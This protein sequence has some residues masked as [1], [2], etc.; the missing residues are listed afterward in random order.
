MPRWAS[1]AGERGSSG[2]GGSLPLAAG[3]PRG[4]RL[5]RQ[6]RRQHAH[7]AAGVGGHDGVHL[8]HGVGQAVGGDEVVVGGA[9]TMV[10]GTKRMVVTD[11]NA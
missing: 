10:R 11:A 2:G 3:A 5:L 9:C 4:R 1:P 6:L 8:G 7:G